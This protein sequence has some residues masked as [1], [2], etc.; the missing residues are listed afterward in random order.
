M[1]E[2]HEAIR[3]LLGRYAEAMDAGDFDAVGELFAAGQLV[4]AGLTLAAGSEAVSKMYRNGTRIHDGSP[5]TRHLN[6]NHIIE[7]DEAEGSAVVR[8]VYVVL[9]SAADFP[10]Q[11]IITGRYV[12]R[13]GRSAGGSWHFTEREFLV[14]QVG[15]L[16]HHL[17]WQPPL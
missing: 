14:D 13:F 8:S 10:L 3:N 7:V 11:A 4:S 6:L 1:S 5:R 9:Q 12:D 17:T 2:A 15:D 16:S